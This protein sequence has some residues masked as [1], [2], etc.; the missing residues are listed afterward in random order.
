M[1]GFLGSPKAKTDTF[2][3]GNKIIYFLIFFIITSCNNEKD[4][5][6]KR[7]M[8]FE[9]SLSIIG[10]QE[11]DKVYNQAYDSIRTWVKNDL[12]DYCAFYH[13]EWEL[14]SLIC[15]N[16]KKDKCIMSLLEACTSNGCTIDELKYFYGVKVDGDWFFFRGPS[17]TLLRERYQRDIHKPIPFD[18]MKDLAIK[19]IYVGYLKKNENHEWVVNDRFFQDLTSVAWGPA[20]NTPEQW[21]STYLAIIRRNWEKRDK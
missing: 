5:K 7:K 2:Y 19:Y 9:K 14:D 17:Y 15:F 20:S 21:D 3:H 8:I 4:I 10:Q 12:S 18:K 13:S 16:I 1:I 6:E 11:Y